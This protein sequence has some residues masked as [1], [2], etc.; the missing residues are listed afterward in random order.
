MSTNLIVVVPAKSIIVPSKQ[1]S[2]ETDRIFGESLLIHLDRSNQLGRRVKIVKLERLL[3]MVEVVKS[4]SEHP[5]IC[6]WSFIG[7]LVKHLRSN[8]EVPLVMEH[9]LSSFLLLGVVNWLEIHDTA[10][11]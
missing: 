9:G 10:E 3:F 1:S 5:V 8:I 6:I 4:N 2:H 11:T 7:H